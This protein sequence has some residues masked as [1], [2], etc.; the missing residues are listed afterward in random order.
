MPPIVPPFL[1]GLLAASVMKKLAKPV[2]RGIVK[3]S[4]GIVAE[5]RH[6]AHQAGEEL[7]DLAAEASAE[8]F[9]TEIKKQK[10]KQSTVANGVPQAAK[11]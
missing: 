8:M 4:I 5:V 7:Q 10:T 11:G 6:A 1:A 2:M 3:T 9:A